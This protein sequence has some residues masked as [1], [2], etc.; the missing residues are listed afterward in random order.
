MAAARVRASFTDDD[1]NSEH[2]TVEMVRISNAPKSSASTTIHH[3]LDEQ[4]TLNES[5]GTPTTNDL[6]STS[7]TALNECV[8]QD[9]EIPNIFTFKKVKQYSF[10]FN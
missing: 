9:Y 10:V 6:L 8:D 7:H 1:S 2:L 3:D 4:A 5:A